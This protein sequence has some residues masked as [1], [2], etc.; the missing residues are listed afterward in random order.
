MKPIWRSPELTQKPTESGISLRD[1]F[2]GKA[3][4]VMYKEMWE[5]ARETGDHP[6][7]WWREG[8]AQDAYRLADAMLLARKKSTV[9]KEKTA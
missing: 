1:Y 3:M 5:D 7:K 4:G 8:L 2:A 9:D 6:P